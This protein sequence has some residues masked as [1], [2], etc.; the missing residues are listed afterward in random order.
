MLLDSLTHADYAQLTNIID[1]IP[2]SIYCKNRDG[3]Y[4]KINQTSLDAMIHWGYLNKDADVSAVIGKTDFDL[5][6]RGSA[7]M[8]QAHDLDIIRSQRVATVEE[9]NTL[10]NSGILKQISTKKPLLNADKQVIGI[11]GA[12][13]IVPQKEQTLRNPL[14]DSLSKRE[15]ECLYLYLQGKTSKETAYL[16]NISFRTVEG[17]FEHI[18]N[19]LNCMSKREL[20]VYRD[21]L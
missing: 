12:T 17:H 6:S 7:E 20:L 9:H 11:M 3:V 19:K 16:L 8:F 18:K 15:K 2:A 14:L 10:P 13:L 4:L 21:L 1:L 5:F